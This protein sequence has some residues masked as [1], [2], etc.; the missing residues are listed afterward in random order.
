MA[1][2]ILVNLQRINLSCCEIERFAKWNRERCY[3]Q[4]VQIERQ[5][6]TVR[7]AYSAIHATDERFLGEIRQTLPCGLASLLHVQLHH[8]HSTLRMPPALKAGIVDQ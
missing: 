8:P 6:L 3:D 1:K 7:N 4:H 2:Y 5:N